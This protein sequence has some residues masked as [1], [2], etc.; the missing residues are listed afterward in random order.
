MRRN[1]NERVGGI[2]IETMR[3]KRAMKDIKYKNKGRR[4]EGIER[5]GRHLVF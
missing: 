1:N 5:Y 4:V 3:Q 2:K